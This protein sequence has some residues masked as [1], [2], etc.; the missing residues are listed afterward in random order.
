[1]ELKIFLL[2]LLI[3]VV[4][5]IVLFIPFFFVWRK[6]CRIYGKDNLAVS[7]RERFTAWLVMCP[8]W[9]VPVLVVKGW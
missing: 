8:L 1:M 6:D 5:Q 2:M 3:C 4:L 9:I 7:L